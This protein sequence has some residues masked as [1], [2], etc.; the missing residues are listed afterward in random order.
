MTAQEVS[1]REED[2]KRT[3]EKQAEEALKPKP[4]TLEQRVAVLETKLNIGE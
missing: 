2:E 3:K 1:A 4:K